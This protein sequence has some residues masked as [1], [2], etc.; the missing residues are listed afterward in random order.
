[1]DGGGLQSAVAPARTSSVGMSHPT[2]PNPLAL[3]HRHDDARHGRLTQQWTARHQGQNAGPNDM[4]I[5]YQCDLR[6]CGC[7]AGQMEGA[8]VLDYVECGASATLQGLATL[9]AIRRG[10]VNHSSGRSHPSPT[11]IVAGRHHQLQLFHLSQLQHV[12]RRARMRC[13][14]GVECTT[15]CLGRLMVCSSQAM[16]TCGRRRRT[17]LTDKRASQDAAGAAATPRP[18]QLELLLSRAIQSSWLPYAGQAAS[19]CS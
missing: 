8:R 9:I 11:S 15:L 6:A 1:M 5:S 3:S 12:P 7:V 2:Q 14:T 13:G 19:L 16:A 10:E 4:L 17:A 18:L